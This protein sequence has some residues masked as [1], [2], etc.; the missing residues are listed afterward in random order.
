MKKTLSTL[1]IFVAGLFL[2]AGAFAAEEKIDQTIGSSLA[3]QPV[4]TELHSANQFIG[5]EVR[6]NSGDKIGEVKDLMFDFNHG[7]GYAVVENEKLSQIDKN[8]LVPLSA[9]QSNHQG[10]YVSLPMSKEALASYP[11]QGSDMSDEAYGRNLYEYHG[12]SYPWTEQT[13]PGNIVPGSER[14]HRLDPTGR[15]IKPGVGG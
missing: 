1:A 5:T 8:I 2:A 11:K 15:P 14:E 10:E 12:L 7:V 13:P 4:Q 3:A 9:F 6:D